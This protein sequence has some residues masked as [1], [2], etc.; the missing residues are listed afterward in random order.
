MKKKIAINGLGRIGRHITKLIVDQHPE[1]ELVAVNDLCEPK[2]LVHLL[3]YDSVYGRYEKSVSLSEGKLVIGDGKSM[4]K[5]AVLAE[6]DPANLPWKDLGVDVVLECTGKFTKYDDVNKHI[7]AG[8]KKV[9][10]S[11]PAKDADK[12]PSFLLGI[13]ADEYDPEKTN[14]MD[15]GSCTT[16]CLAPMLKVL[17][18]TF[19]VEKGFMSTIH[20]YTNDQRILDFAHKDL[21]RTRAAALNIIPTT[22]GAAKAIGKV[23]PS[24]KGKID[25]IALRVPVP[26]T[27]V[28]DLFCV[29]KKET[30]AEEVN[31]ALEK[32]TVQGPLKGIMAYEKEPLVSSDFIGCQ[33]SSIVDAALTMANGNIV[34][35]VSWYDNEW[36]YATRLA[37]FAAFI[38]NKI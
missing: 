5:V 38:A 6:T 8:A 26:T 15:M 35:V 31:A 20:A 17:N 34:K 36:G 32:A 21:R 12:V 1:L 37:E 25:G 24:L 18:D 23:I 13:N 19:G 10:I 28:V 4:Q 33:Y 11:A 16:N 29:I 22:T 30:T 2:V 3:K 27:S 7:T 14:I 9:I